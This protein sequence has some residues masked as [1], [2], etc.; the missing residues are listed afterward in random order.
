MRLCI[1]LTA[2]FQNPAGIGRYAIELAIALVNLQS[3]EEISFFYN[4]PK[5]RIPRPPLD[6]FPRKVIR[7]PKKIWTLSMLMGT[8]TRI[9]MDELFGNADVYHATDHMLPNC[10]KTKTV[11]TLHDTTFAVCPQTHTRL[12][13]WSSNLMVPIFLKACHRVIADSNNT[14]KDA[15]RLYGI[16]PGKITVVYPGVTDGFRQVGAVEKKDLK[17][18]YRLPDRFFLYVG[19]IEPRKNLTLLLDSYRN[20]INRGATFSLVIA[21]KKGWMYESFFRKLSDLDLED[22]V[23]LPGFVPDDDLPTLY[24][25]AL[26][27]LFPSLYEGFGFPVLEAMACGT[28]VICSNTS[29]LPEVAGDAALLL[30]PEDVQAWVEAIERVSRDDLLRAD[31]SRR[32]Q[33]QASR[34]R[35]ENTARQTLQV[36]REVCEGSA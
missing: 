7:C 11:I 13:R 36:Y 21:G 22:K 1:D 17:V 35:W 23:V 33:L 25:A 12:L 28:P 4:D 26:G 19:T 14:K 6:L 3:G 15:M 2:G 32:G 8:L 31:L 30:P 10:R 5:G 9:G 34:F 29:S 18:R 24:S 27:F 20:L 16:D